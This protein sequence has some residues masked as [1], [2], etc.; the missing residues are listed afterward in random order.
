MSFESDIVATLGP[1]VDGRIFPDVAPFNTPRPYIIYQ[2][3]GGAP[4]NY[5][6]N[7][8]PDHANA[9]IQVSVWDD[10]RLTANTICRLAE[11]ALRIAT[12]F[13]SRPASGLAA[14]YDD[15]TE[16]FGAQQDFS[17]WYAR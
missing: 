5:I 17:I 6:D 3:I 13:Q 2:Q 10:T 15:S 16:R 8:V 12:V 14:L 4:L 9:E 11:D 1:L 7:T